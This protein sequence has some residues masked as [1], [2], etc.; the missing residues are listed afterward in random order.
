MHHGSSTLEVQ[1]LGRL[2][3]EHVCFRN[4][5]KTSCC[6]ASTPALQHAQPVIGPFENLEY[7]RHISNRFEHRPCLVCDLPP[8]EK[9]GGR[10]FR[11]LRGP[12]THNTRIQIGRM[13]QRENKTIVAIILGYTTGVGSGRVARIPGRRAERKMLRIPFR[14]RRIC[15]TCPNHKETHCRG[16]KKIMPPALFLHRPWWEPLVL[17]HTRRFS[18]YPLQHT[19]NASPGLQTSPPHLM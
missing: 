18:C 15:S 5:R 17:K 4:K 10:M 2:C 14:T 19:S 13:T 16:T 12:F 9:G 11:P 3:A 8:K 7:T 6:L 1:Q